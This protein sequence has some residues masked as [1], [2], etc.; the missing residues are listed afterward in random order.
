MV[1]GAL[2]P[3]TMDIEQ[4][5]NIRIPGLYIFRVESQRGPEGKVIEYKTHVCY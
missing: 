5:S 1:P 2:T 4:T 3:A